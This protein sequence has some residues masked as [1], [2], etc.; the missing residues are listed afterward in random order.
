MAIIKTISS[1]APLKTAINYIKNPDKT[2]HNLISGWG[3]DPDNAEQ[4][5][6]TTKKYWGKTG[7]R[8]YKHFVQSFAPGDN[9]TPE[10]AHVIA[11]ETVANNPK[12]ANYEV[13]IVTHT[14]PKQPHSHIIVNSVNYQN[15]H[16]YQQS[17]RDLKNL[18]ALSDRICVA[19][20]L[21]VTTKGKTHGGADRDAPTT[22][23]KATYN[24][25]L[26]AQ[27]AAEQP[28]PKH[29]ISWMYDMAEAAVLTSQQAISRADWRELM[30]QKGYEVDWQDTHKHIVIIDIVRHDAGERKCK[31]RTGT[32]G[33][34][35][36][37][38][39]SKE[40]LEDGFAHNA[41]RAVQSAEA[42]VRS[43]TAIQSA[44]S[45]AIAA[46]DAANAAAERKARDSQQQRSNTAGHRKQT[47]DTG[48]RSATS[49]S[50]QAGANSK[51]ASTR[52]QR[53]GAGS[54]PAR[55]R[56]KARGDDYCL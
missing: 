21:A 34:R 46:A 38:N 20:G 8:T 32:L 9:I 15:G 25:L 53:A 26:K 51:G 16:K 30:L 18:K 47:A 43:A 10:K 23:N 27:A 17:K 29:G 44:A 37:I 3:C 28:V 48:S 12:W 52:H 42:A 35:F 33:D 45:T 49:G 22:Y 55:R 24:R 40:D 2:D 41:T 4:D 6:M 19:H 14:G 13:L 11:W 5:M 31:A 7:G 56:G 1:A 50:Q 39:L 54:R 36:N